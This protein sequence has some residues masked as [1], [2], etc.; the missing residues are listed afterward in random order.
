MAEGKRIHVAFAQP[1]GADWSAGAIFY[2]NV[3]SAL[4]SLDEEIRPRISIIRQDSEKENEISALVDGVI[5]FSAQSRSRTTIGRVL[6]NTGNRLVSPLERP[7]K[8]AGVDFLFTTHLPENWAPPSIPVI[9][10][11]PDFQHLR[12]PEF[13]S[14]SDI[15]GRNCQFL[16][17]LRKAKTVVVTSKDVRN[18]LTNFFPAYLEKCKLLNFA[19]TIPA[20]MLQCE[21]KEIADRYGL[22]ERFFYLPNQFWK[23]KNHLLVLDALERAV[24]ECPDLTVVATGNLRDYRHPD[25]LDE[26]LQL[27]STKKLRDN[28]IVLGL[29]PRPHTFALMRGCVAVLQPSL[30][31]GLSMTVAESAVVGKQVIASDID[32]LRELASAGTVFFSPNDPAQLAGLLLKHHREFA[33]VSDDDYKTAMSNSPLLQRRFADSLMSAFS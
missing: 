26:L 12:M 16:H 14:K 3:F 21:P 29:I 27:I 5:T 33:G 7:L 32:V 19:T 13:F 4:K 24:K 8:E 2:S 30:F 28:F 15:D 10:W 22:P 11:I 6:R 20:E 31:E 17:L 25:F 9:A 18:D 1:G 23:H